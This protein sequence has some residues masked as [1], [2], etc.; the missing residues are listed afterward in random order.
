MSKLTAKQVAEMPTPF[1]R[2]PRRDS[3]EPRSWQAYGGN[4]GLAGA[5]R[6]GAHA[7][8]EGKVLTDCPY[9]DHRTMR[10]GVTF[11]RAFE[12]AWCEG[13]HVAMYGSRDACRKIPNHEGECDLR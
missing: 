2:D 6:K 13:W 7:A 3:G 9:Y 12:K 1:D 8:T 4:R 10:G 5:F 11:S